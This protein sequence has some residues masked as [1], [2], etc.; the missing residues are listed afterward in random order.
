MEAVP[1]AAAAEVVAEPNTAEPPPSFE[2]P[3]VAHAKKQ[4]KS[5]TA[6][7]AR[8]PSGKGK[9]D[10]C[11]VNADDGVENVAE[12]E[13]RVER[14]VVDYYAK[15][16]KELMK[17][18][19]VRVNKSAEGKPDGFRVGLAKCSILREGGLR[20]GDVVKNVNGLV[21][22]DLFSAVGAYL[23]LR[24]EPVIELEVERKGKRVTMRYE[25]V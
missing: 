7:K 14:D 15:H 16:V 13:W 4:G 6:S 12:G 18:G 22:H 1:P 24:R 17:L 20:S 11:P 8:K 23:K 21:V 25:L 10:T 2:P 19:S 3:V 5:I 9:V